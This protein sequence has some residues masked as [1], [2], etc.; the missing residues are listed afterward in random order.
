M[1]RATLP[2]LVALA[3]AGCTDSKEDLP[4]AFL[5][6]AGPHDCGEG[7]IVFVMDGGVHRM[8]ADG[9]AVMALTTGPNDSAPR[10]SPDG[11]QIAFLR[12]GGLCIMN[13]DGGNPVMRHAGPFYRIAWSP[14]GRFIAAVWQPGEPVSV[15]DVDS[16]TVGPAGEPVGYETVTWSPD[17]QWIVYA[18]VAELRA[19]RPDGTDDRS[20]FGIDGSVS[21]IA[22]SP[23][24]GP[25]IAVVRRLGRSDRVDILGTE[26]DASLGYVPFGGIAASD[27]I[28]DPFWSPDHGC[29]GVTIP[30]ERAFII[31]DLFT[32]QERTF[33]GTMGDW[34]RSIGD[35]PP[36]AAFATT[37]STVAV[38]ESVA[39]DP[40]AS[41]DDL[42]IVEYVWDFDGNDV[43]NLVDTKEQVTKFAFDAPGVY[44]ARLTVRDTAGNEDT[45][46]RT[47]TVTGEETFT[48]TIQFD[49]SVA[50]TVVV[51]VDGIHVQTCT[52]TCEVKTRVG[53]AVTLT[54]SGEFYGWIDWDVDLGAGVC[55]LTMN[56]DRTVTLLAP[57]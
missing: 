33:A 14:G 16:R 30:S 31:R 37:P 52:A 28:R 12:N 50:S 19:V 53:A 41:S 40:S 49:P 55:T 1:S 35:A 23:D 2:L 25:Y 44:E 51:N 36:V 38:G 3:L 21:F 27:E 7:H 45:T 10:W 15:Y 6:A 17:G 43:V 46:T 48:L 20:L 24:P 26:N 13:A 8:R 34:V 47:V 42:G 57:S 4:R 9:T 56:A 22:W 5:A 32:G 39:F 11:R 29:L 54:A 18:G